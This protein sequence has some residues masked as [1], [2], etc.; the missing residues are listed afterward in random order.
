MKA[1]SFLKFI[2]VNYDN[3]PEYIAFIHGH[4]TAPHQYHPDGILNA[5]DSANLNNYEYI[6]L[7]NRLQSIIYDKNMRFDRNH[8]DDIYQIT[9]VAHVLMKKAWPIIYQPELGIP[10]PEKLRYQQSAQFIVSR[11]KIYSHPKEFYEKLYRFVT[12]PYDIDPQTTDYISACV[13]EFS[14][15]MIFGEKPDMCDTAPNDPL[16]NSCNDNIYLDH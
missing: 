5:I 16:Y 15:H 8:P 2:I 12:Y 10:F 1:S 4:E 13:L 7:N 9:D 14:W 3:L 6:S 11:N